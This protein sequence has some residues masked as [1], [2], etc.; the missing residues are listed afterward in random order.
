[1]ILGP[2]FFKLKNIFYFK[3][4]FSRFQ[5]ELQD[6]TQRPIA[7][8]RSCIC[9]LRG[10]FAVSSRGLLRIRLSAQ[11]ISSVYNP[12]CVL[13]FFALLFSKL[14]LLIFLLFFLPKIVDVAFFVCASH[15]MSLARVCFVCDF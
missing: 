5:P 11:Y 7:F 12:L 6:C 15:A 2:N 4:R 10:F 14:L 1:M 8:N 9:R 3:N 13:L